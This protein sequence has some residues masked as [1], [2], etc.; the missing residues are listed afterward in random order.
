M[1][2]FLLFALLVLPLAFMSCRSDNEPNYPDQT[3][4]VGDT[5]RIP[6][7]ETGW[8]S[9]NELVA[10]VSGSTVTAELVGE[11]VIRN[12]S[13]SFKV[14]VTGKSKLF[15]EPYMRFGASKSTV[16]SVMSS[17]TLS[18]ETTETLL[19]NGTYPVSYYLYGFKNEA[20][21]LSSLVIP[22][23]SVTAENL[24]D[25][26]KER[27]LYVTSNEA[28]HY[29]GFISPDMKTLVVL[30]INTFNSQVVYMISYGEYTGSSSV[31]AQVMKIA[32]QNKTTEATMNMSTINREYSRLHEI[33]P[34]INVEYN[35]LNR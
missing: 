24:V 18:K 31:P 26:L 13:K 30:N 34:E 27:Y 9:D 8:T 3:L 32:K 19:Y 21:N 35:I 22:V 2:K 4:V 28:E 33:M 17:Y 1:K 15:K 12:G 10:S 6:G 25:F 16:K 23:T 11:T 5:Y 29:F 7:G 20:M 14:T